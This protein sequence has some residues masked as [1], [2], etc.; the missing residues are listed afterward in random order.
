[1]LSKIFYDKTMF[2]MVSDDNEREYFVVKQYRNNVAIK[3]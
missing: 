1:M 3:L 2:L